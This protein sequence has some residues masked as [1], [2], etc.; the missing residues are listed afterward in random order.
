M[1]EIDK[2]FI[3]NLADRNFEFFT[4]VRLIH[5]CIFK[6]MNIIFIVIVLSY[7]ILYTCLRRRSNIFFFSIFNFSFCDMN[8]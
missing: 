6:Y 5:F 2:T 3:F 8:Y 4:F 7:F 1:L